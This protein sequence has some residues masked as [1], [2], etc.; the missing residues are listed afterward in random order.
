MVISQKL[1][2]PYSLISFSKGYLM[3]KIKFVFSL[4]VLLL[5]ASCSGAIPAEKIDFPKTDIVYQ[6]ISNHFDLKQPTDNVIGFVNADGSG[7]ALIKIKYRAHQPVFSKAWD[8]VFFIEAREQYEILPYSGYASF[9]GSNGEY[10]RC[11]SFGGNLYAGFVFPINGEKYVLATNS[12]YIQLLSLEDCNITKTLIQQHDSDKDR[13]E[14]SAFPSNAGDQVIFNF[15]N[16]ALGTYQI[17]IMDINTG[18]IQNSLDGGE[19]PSFSP[20]GT[21]IAYTKDDGIYIADVNGPNRQRLVSLSFPESFRLGLL[22]TPFWSPD[23]TLLIYHKCI[24]QVCHD[25]SDFSIYK[26]DVT[27]GKQTKIVDGGLFPVWIK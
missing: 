17:K 18:K 24:N 13:I 22:P 21:R 26:V 20:D 5:S 2:D 16:Q 6:A 3:K 9:L 25:L 4:I 12:G 10:K 14:S 11:D 15:Q 7:N 23:G 27:T 8:G 1:L 19:N